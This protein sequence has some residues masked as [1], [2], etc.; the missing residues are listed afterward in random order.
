MKMRLGFAALIIL[1]L[2]QPVL[3]GFP[4]WYPQEGFAHYGKIDEVNARSK[5]I[6]I[7][8]RE[9]RYSDS[10]VVHSLSETSDSLARLRKNVKVGFTYDTSGGGSKQLLEVWLL[11]ENY[12]QDED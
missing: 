3:A 7:N 8:D 9:Y 1:L 4:D 2:S 11:P 10:T 5:T 6:I 12:S